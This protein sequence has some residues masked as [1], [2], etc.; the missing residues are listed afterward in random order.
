MEHRAR[1]PRSRRAVA[2]ACMSCSSMAS[3]RSV[4]R[5][6]GGFTPL[7]RNSSS[8]TRRFKAKPEERFCRV[9]R[10]P[11]KACRPF[12]TYGIWVVTTK[13]CTSAPMPPSRY[14][15]T[16]VE[17][18]GWRRGCAWFP[19]HFEMP[20]TSSSRSIDT[21]G[22]ANSTAADYPGPK[23]VGDFYSYDGHVSG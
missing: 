4:T 22:S 15:A 3:A 18:G 21:G 9:T 12:Y 7:T 1:R 2:S 16:S 11:T 14:C 10:T 13:L 8:T 5:R 6:C 17:C 20:F 19:A 23:T